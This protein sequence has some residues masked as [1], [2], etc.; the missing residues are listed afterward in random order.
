L[1]I[2]WQIVAA[3]AGLAGII[4]ARMILVARK[5]VALPPVCCGAALEVKPAPKRS[6]KTRWLDAV[7]YL[8][9]QREWRYDT[10]WVLL[11]GEAGAGKSSL[12]ASLSN[13]DEPDARQR[14]LAVDNTDWHFLAQGVLIDPQGDLP[15][16]AS[17]RA[18]RNR[19]NGWTYWIGSTHCVQSARSTACCWLSRPVR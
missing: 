11:L 19:R 4:V 1:T 8:R 17:N 9:T 13:R 15:A 10:P 6:W 12:A 7:D 3:V 14:K 2:M 16:A 5:P 18:R